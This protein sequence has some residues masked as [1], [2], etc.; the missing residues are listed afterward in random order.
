MKKVAEASGLA[1]EVFG[2]QQ[3]WCK[4]CARA[5]KVKDPNKVFVRVASAGELDARRADVRA[6][7][8][9]SQPVLLIRQ[10]DFMPGE[11]EAKFPLDTAIIDGIRGD[12]WHA[13]FP[14]GRDRVKG[15]ESGW[16]SSDQLM[17]AVVDACLFFYAPAK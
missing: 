14:Y 11:T 13:V 1:D 9:R 10:N 4:K 16:C 2:K 7:L 6:A 17:T 12:E 8:E 5:L 3:D 15:S